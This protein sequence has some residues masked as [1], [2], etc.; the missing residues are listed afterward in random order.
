M[1]VENSENTWW[2]I[3]EESAT[4]KS[5]QANKNTIFEIDY[6]KQPIVI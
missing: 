1:A 4:W 5:F 3:S 2:S 6:L